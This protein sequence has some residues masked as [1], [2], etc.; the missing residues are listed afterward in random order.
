MDRGVGAART[1]RRWSRP[2]RHPS[3][4]SSASSST[5]SVVAGRDL[6]LRCRRVARRPPRRPPC[7]RSV[8]EHPD[9]TRPGSC[10]TRHSEASPG[11]AIRS[12]PGAESRATSRSGSTGGTRED[13]LDG[14]VGQLVDGCDCRARTPGRRRRRP[15]TP[16]RDGRRRLDV[17]P[18]RVAERSTRVGEPA[19]AGLRAPACGSARAARTARGRRPASGLAVPR[20][21]GSAAPRG[22]AR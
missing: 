20:S 10:S 12:R 13:V 15:S 4:A 21:S 16:G 17:T 3:S 18:L 1:G 5:R 9:P 22:R 8:G 6:D 2:P 14:A 11:L 7:G 19:V